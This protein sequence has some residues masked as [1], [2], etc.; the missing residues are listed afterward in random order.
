MLKKNEHGDKFV[1]EEG[2]E[3]DNDEEYHRD[4]PS[5]RIFRNLFR[6]RSE[7]FDDLVLAPNALI[8]D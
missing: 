5:P 6:I 8:R 1:A 3:G 4:Q 2:R 7:V